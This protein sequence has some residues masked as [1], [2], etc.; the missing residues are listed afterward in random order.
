M[1]L[2]TSAYL[3]LTLYHAILLYGLTKDLEQGCHCSASKRFWW[4]FFA[5]DFR[6]QTQMRAYSPLILGDISFYHF[7]FIFVSQNCWICMHYLFISV[8]RYL[9]YHVLATEQVE[10]IREDQVNKTEIT[11]EVQNSSIYNRFPSKTLYLIWTVQ[12]KTHCFE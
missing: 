11:R 4:G 8:Q 9:F 6:R 2:D 1:T 3:S 7:E 12:R 5:T 10:Q